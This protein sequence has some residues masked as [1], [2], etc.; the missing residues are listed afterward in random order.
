[1]PEGLDKLEKQ[2]YEA[3]AGLMQK[4][5]KEDPK[6]P[7]VYRFLAKAYEG[8]WRWVEAAEAC[9]K[10]AGFRLRDEGA[11]RRHAGHLRAL[12]DLCFGMHDGLDEGKLARLK[13]IADDPYPYGIA[14]YAAYEILARHAFPGN[15]REL[16]NI[17]EHAFILCRGHVIGREHLPSELLDAVGGGAGREAV[18]AME[19]PLEDAEAGAIRAVLR[20]HKGNQ[21]HAA[22]EL[23]IHR[24]TLWRKMK[25]HGIEVPEGRSR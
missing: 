10:L 18:A 2:D 4:A 19:H 25:R 23:G 22:D 15:V 16:E 8:Q 24:T 1:M 3:A 17:I 12:A 5:A 11:I 9:E 7:Q 21:C 6:C 13:T 14:R 20:K